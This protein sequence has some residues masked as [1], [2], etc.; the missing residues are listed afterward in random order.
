[1]YLAYSGLR[2][3]ECARR[4]ILSNSHVQLIT[5]I[6]KRS[7]INLIVRVWIEQH[8]L[9]FIYHDNHSFNIIF[10]HHTNTT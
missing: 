3:G 4:T 8:C 5:L 10:I 6:V 7:A 9:D 2:T 1:M